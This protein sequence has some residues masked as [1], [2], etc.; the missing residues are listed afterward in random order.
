MFSQKRSYVYVGLRMPNRANQ[1]SCPLPSAQLYKCVR[2]RVRDWLDLICALTLFTLNQLTGSHL[3]LPAQSK[4][5][6]IKGPTVA[7]MSLPPPCMHLY[8]LFRS[9]WA[10]RLK[11]CP[12]HSSSSS[13]SLVS[14]PECSS[15]LSALEM[16]EE[17][18]LRTT[19]DFHIATSYRVLLSAV[20]GEV[21]ENMLLSRRL[22]YSIL[23]C[24]MNT[25]WMMLNRLRVT[26]KWACIWIKLHFHVFRTTLHPTKQTPP[27]IFIFVGPTLTL[28][29]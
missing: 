20:A 8:S 1:F 9:Y 17:L 25:S 12:L 11:I 28:N 19:N 29:L 24:L 5:R 15:V 2:A 26:F 18:W 14:L 7:L 21:T 6:H 22:T 3:S 23:Q 4:Y 27:H 13:S 16:C 10:H